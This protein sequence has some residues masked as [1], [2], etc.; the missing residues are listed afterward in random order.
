MGPSPD[1][2]TAVTHP[3]PYPYYAGLVSERPLY[4]DDALGV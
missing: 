3:D 4:R 1:P 2:V